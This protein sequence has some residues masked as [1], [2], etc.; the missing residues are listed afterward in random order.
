MTA[1]EWLR[2]NG[3]ADL[4]DEIEEVTLAWRAAGKSTRRDWW[5][6]LAGRADGSPRRAGG[7]EWP[8][9]A[10]ARE[11]Q[12]LPPAEI[13]ISRS[14]GEE[15]PPVRRTGRWPTRTATE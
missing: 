14:D 15:P 4:A 3:Y 12:G 9:L 10:V 2:N 11:R 8:V 1:R 13:A 6:V 5:D 7:R